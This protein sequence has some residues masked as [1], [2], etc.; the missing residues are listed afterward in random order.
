MDVLDQLD[1]TDGCLH[2]ITTDYASSNYSMTCKLQS[3]LEA[4]G[5]EWPALRNHIPCMAQ[6]V[7]QAVGPFM[8]S[9]SVKCRTK[10]WEAQERNLQF[11]ENESIGIGKSQRLQKEGNARINKVSAMR[12][13]LAKIFEKVHISWYFECSETDLN[14]AEK[15]CGIDY[16]DTWSWKQ[17]IDCQN[18]KVRIAVIPIMGV[19][20][21]WNSTLEFFEHTYPLQ[22]FTRKWLQN[23]K[24]TD[25]QP[26]FTTQDDWTIVK[27]V[28]EV[29][30]QFRY[31][32]PSGCQRGIQTHCTTLSQCKMTCSI[33]W[34]AWS[35][36]WLR[37]RLHGRKTCCWLWS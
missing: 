36:L 20:T 8:S 30:R 24:H 17:F 33:T 6:V 7:Q 31:I 21:F 4:S 19:Q 16:A 25:Y 37:R 9:L 2:G 10:S 15:A 18:A 13:G 12:P 26:L 29:L 1:L 35:Y 11:G 27:Y 5:I 28:M 14:I 23:P 34:M 32:G 22:E 3:T